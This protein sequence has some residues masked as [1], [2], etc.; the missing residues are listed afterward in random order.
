[1]TVAVDQCEAV[2]GAW[3]EVH[4][5]GSSH[6]HWVPRI[7][8]SQAS[9]ARALVVGRSR[10]QGALASSLGQSSATNRVRST[11]Q[12]ARLNVGIDPACRR[13]GTA[14]IQALPSAVAFSRQMRGR[15]PWAVHCPRAPTAG[16]SRQPVVRRP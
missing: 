5:K 3:V 6:T 2:A 9:R 16:Q 4:D 7:A 14:S 8:A 11:E 12:L 15:T 13:V 1:L 10:R